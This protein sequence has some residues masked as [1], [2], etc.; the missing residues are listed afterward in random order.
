MNLRNSLTTTK[1]DDLAADASV[2]DSKMTDWDTCAKD[3]EA[4]KTNETL[5]DKLC[6]EFTLSGENKKTEGDNRS[7]R[8][9]DKTIDDVDKGTIKAPTNRL[10]VEPEA[11]DGEGGVSP[12]SDAT[13]A[14]LETDYESGDESAKKAATDAEDSTNS[15]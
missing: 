11:D 7:M 4:C 2:E 6:A 5:L 14:N 3:K 12:T 8:Y 13:G 1:P 10:L 9:G 15:S